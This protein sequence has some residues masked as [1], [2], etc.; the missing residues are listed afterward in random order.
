M[1][2]FLF[3]MEAIE[4]YQKQ[5]TSILPPAFPSFFLRD[6]AHTHILPPCRKNHAS[7]RSFFHYSRSTSLP[8]LLGNACVNPRVKRIKLDPALGLIPED[9]HKIALPPLDPGPKLC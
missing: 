8:L 9:T 5:H 3:K 4:L 1:L 7:S 6:H 2:L